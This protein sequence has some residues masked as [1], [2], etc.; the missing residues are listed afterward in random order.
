MKE[1]VINNTK[2]EL[3][4]KFLSF[5]RKYFTDKAGNNK[6]YEYVSRNNNQKAVIV[7]P[8]LEENGIN[9]IVL[10]RQF[11]IP[12]DNYS[13]EFPAGL[14][15]EGETPQQAAIRELIEETGY[16]GEI[17]EVSSSSYTSPGLTTEEVYF[18]K[19]RINEKGQQELEDSEEIEVLEIDR[20]GWYKLV[21]SGEHIQS[22]PYLFCSVYFK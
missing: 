13:I 19:I 8:Y 3:Q 1:I 18:V 11:R 21:K 7:I 2:S 15:D 4:G 12:V 17:F 6:E 5:N 10:I 14:I 22:W 20:D 16:R 9:K